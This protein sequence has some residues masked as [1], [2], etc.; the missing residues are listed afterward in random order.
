MDAATPS[1]DPRRGLRAALANNTFRS[2]K[3]RNYRLYFFGQIVSYTGSWAQS[4]ALQWLVYELTRD[5]FWSALFLVAQVA[6][7][8]LLGPL[9]GAISDRFPRK[10]VVLV[11]QSAFA[12]NATLLVLLVSFNAAPVGVLLALQII[13]GVI[14]GVDLPARL[15]FVPELVSKDDLI[16]AVALNSTLF[17][18]ARLVG[19]AVAG[20][21]FAVMAQVSDSARV[22]AAVCFGLNAVSYI[23]VLFA[24]IRITTGN[25]R[26]R[27]AGAKPGSIWDGIR[28]LQSHSSFGLLVVFTGLFASFAWPVVTLL[29]A[30]TANVLGL[31]QQTYSLLVSALGGGALL[32]ALVTATFGSVKRR[33]IFL[34][35]GTTV[36]TLALAALAFVRTPGSAAAA[37]A[38]CG[39]GLITYLSTSQSILQLHSPDECRGRVMALWAMTLS[40]SAPIGHLL[41]GKAAQYFPIPH[42]ILTL[43]S[44]V[45]ATLFGLIVLVAGTRGLR[46]LPSAP[47]HQTLI[48]KD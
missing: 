3:H 43:A 33:E 9:G 11:S 40:A 4:A 2:L 38:G 29:P 6:P 31:Q 27:P 20:A 10:R 15:A 30:Y 28:F 23:A 1:I 22:G 37:C 19:P 17:N 5:T 45:G 21:V 13:S 47:S 48:V 34:L 42:V 26:P 36:G 35:G 41:V 25:Q 7:T 16:N 44:G 14:Q 46:N 12:L 39:F 18:A 32:G 8:L 24:L